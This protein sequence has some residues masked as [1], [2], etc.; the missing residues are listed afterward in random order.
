MVKGNALKPERRMI[1]RYMSKSLIVAVAVVF[2]LCLSV[3]AQAQESPF[4]IEN[5]PNVVGVAVGVIPDYE[6][7]NDYTVGV[8]PFAKLTY[9]KSEWYLRLLATDLQLNILNHPWLRLGPAVNYRWGRKD[10]EDKV[11]KHMKDIDGTIEA[12]GFI[13]VEFITKDNPRQRFI[14]Q[15]EFLSDVGNTYKGYNATLTATFWQPIHKMIDIAI[16]GGICYADENYMET[17]FGVT[18]VN[19]DR[20]GLPVFEADSGFKDFRVNPA[21]VVHLSTDWHVAAGLQYRYMLGDAHDSPVVKD[22]G[23]PNSQWIMG[24]GVAYSWM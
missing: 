21:V 4:N 20:T 19:S 17:Y 15:I 7:S 16:G 6:G 8:A 13:G 1:M 9:P 11:V 24:V 3:A 18:Q 10:V 23:C 14:S 22:R 2:A 5:V 12:G